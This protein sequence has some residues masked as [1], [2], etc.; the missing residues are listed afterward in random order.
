M[1]KQK[2]SY[3]A[4][5]RGDLVLA[6]MIIAFA[7]CIHQHTKCLKEEVKQVDLTGSLMKGVQRTE[8]DDGDFWFLLYKLLYNF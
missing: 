4:T 7:F 2:A 3:W 6:S 5:R 8:Y 1:V